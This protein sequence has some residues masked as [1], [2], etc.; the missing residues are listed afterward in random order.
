MET[1]RVGRS[2]DP[3]DLVLLG[4]LQAVTEAPILARVDGYLKTRSVDLGV[5]AG[6]PVAEIDA[7]EL[8]HQLHQAQAAVTHAEASIEQAQAA[9]DQAKANRDL[10]QVTA[11]RWKTLTAQGVVSRQDN[12]QYQAQLVS[13]NAN[14]QALETAVAAQRSGLTS[15]QAN[16]ARL[17]EVLGCRVVRA[18]FDGV[19][20]LRNVDVGA[21]GERR[22]YAAAAARL[23]E[24]E[25]GGQCHRV[26]EFNGFLQR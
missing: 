23:P 17:Q 15:S 16:V 3:S 6:Q 25:G 2:S 14:V 12:D 22:Q 10:A 26:H 8:D 21:P 19:V 11:E 24:S 1:T 9:L 4:T 20:V 7:P 5:H 18:P 13:S